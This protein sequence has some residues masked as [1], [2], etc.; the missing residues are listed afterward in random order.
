MKKTKKGLMT[1]LERAI[2]AYYENMTPEELEAERE[3]E[4]AIAGADKGIDVDRD[5]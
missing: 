2:E 5:E 4:D 1:P 3:L